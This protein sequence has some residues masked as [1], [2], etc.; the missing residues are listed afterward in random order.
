MQNAHYSY[1]LWTAIANV[2]DLEEKDPQFLARTSAKTT[3][4]T[5]ANR[6]TI[7]PTTTSTNLGDTLDLATVMKASQ[8]IS[9]EIVLSKLL[10]RLMRIAIENA[11]AQK[12]FLISEKAGNWTIEAEDSVKMDVESSAI[13]KALSV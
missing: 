10:E 9:G 12:G 4:Q 5:K 3:P 13:Y 11:G 2:E 7:K 1:Q 6:T 8:A